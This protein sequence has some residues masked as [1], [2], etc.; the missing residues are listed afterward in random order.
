M[1]L[2]DLQVRQWDNKGIGHGPVGLELVCV[3]R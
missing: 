2:Q 3:I 1:V